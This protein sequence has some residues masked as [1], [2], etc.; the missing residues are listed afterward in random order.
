[1]KGYP[2]SFLLKLNFIVLH[3]LKPNPPAKTSFFIA[4]F[5]EK[6]KTDPIKHPPNNG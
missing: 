4:V 3:F 6:Q 2:N 5:F 1:M